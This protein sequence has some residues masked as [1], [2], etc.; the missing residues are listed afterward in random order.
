MKGTSSIYYT[1]NPQSFQEVRELFL[2]LKDIYYDTKSNN[3]FPPA[4]R[5]FLKMESF[6]N[7]V[8]DIKLKTRDYLAFKKRF[9]Q[10]G[11][12]K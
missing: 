3:D 2:H 8:N 9:Y 6:T 12:E 4:I 1:Y 11:K 7:V 5:D 10:P